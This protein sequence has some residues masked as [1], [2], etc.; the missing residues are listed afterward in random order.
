MTR[1][2]A[3][4]VLALLLILASSLPSRAH[5]N[6]DR[7]VPVSRG[8]RPDVTRWTGLVEQYDWHV[9]TIL[10]IIDCE[11]GGDPN[12]VNPSSGAKGLAQLYLWDW[13]ARRL[14]GYTNL[15]D[16]EQNIAFA[17]FLYEDSGQRFGFHWL[18]SAGC[19]R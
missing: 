8:T 13:T 4:L 6:G 17:Y 1:V 19:W 5:E 16:P 7:Y 18:A 15:F 3:A 9:P 10:R 2:N 11:S 14:F 12:A